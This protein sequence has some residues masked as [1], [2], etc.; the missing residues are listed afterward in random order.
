MRTCTG[1][2]GVEMQIVINRSSLSLNNF[3]MQQTIV[4]IWTCVSYDP[5]MSWSRHSYGEQLTV[6][7]VTT[8]MAIMR[9]AFK[10]R[11]RANVPSLRVE[12]RNWSNN[13]AKWFIIPYMLTNFYKP[14]SISHLFLPSP[15][16]D[17]HDLILLRTVFKVSIEF[18]Q[19]VLSYCNC[20]VL[21]KSYEYD[22]SMSYFWWRDYVSSVFKKLSIHQ[23]FQLEVHTMLVYYMVLLYK[24]RTKPFYFNRIMLHPYC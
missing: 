24:P 14:M 16:W 15:S 2:A 8:D 21:T 22:M 20:N 7:A 6:S 17:Q 23:C 9:P 19:P 12:Y 18:V 1:I 5:H 11:W 3:R 13:D 10:V 4:V